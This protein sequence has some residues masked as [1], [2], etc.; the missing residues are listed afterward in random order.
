MKNLKI[1]KEI[2][3]PP[4]AVT[5]T[6]GIIGRKGAGKTYLATMVAEQM[7]DIKAQTIIVDPVGVWWGLRINADGK[8]KGKQIFVIG[9]D[10]GDIPLV[11]EAGKKVAQ[12]LVEKGISAV[13]DVSSFGVSEHKR[14]CADFGEEFFQ[15]KKKKRSP[16]MLMLEEAQLVVPQNIRLEEARMYSAFERIVRLGRNYGIGTTLITQRPQSVNKEVL[17]QVE[18]L[19]VLQVTGP[20]ER[21]ALE[22]WVQEVGADRTL[23]GELP[24]LAR[25]EGY[26]WSPQWLGIFKRVHFSKKTTFD[27]SATPEVGKAVQAASLSAVDVEKLKEDM[28]EVISQ[29]EKDDPVALRRQIAE[30]Q[31][32]AKTPVKGGFQQKFVESDLKK[33]LE[34]HLVAIAT[35]RNAWALTV[36]SWENYVEMF[37]EIV[38]NA[39]IALRELDKK[40]PSKKPGATYTPKF[41]V[42]VVNTPRTMF[43]GTHSVVVKPPIAEKPQT[44]TPNEGISGPEQ[45]ILDAIA[46]QES[47]GVDHPEQTAVAFLAGY[48]VGGGAFNNPKGSLRK[49]GLIEYAGSTLALTAEGRSMAH[50]PE[51][52]LTTEALHEKV[53]ARLDGP[54]QRIL[55]P[56][57]EAYPNGLSNEELAQASGYELGGG[58]FNNPKGRL[59]T[60]G[61]IEYL[62][63][64]QSKAKDILFIK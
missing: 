5:Q 34:P 56:L 40:R 53:L 29:A 28:A 19:C 23:I 48:K 47:I 9:G 14:F 52:E 44:N 36:E 11:P 60:L 33:A 45:R 21:K 31:K 27:A 55:K 50:V 25:G 54:Q 43:V 13:V 37:R 1:S 62:P 2:S 51:G 16:A 30:L 59:K 38:N 63:G 6:I 41:S 15:L 20:H 57:L 10:H 39:T 61:L 12:L 4:D 22:Y 24:G 64:G 35:E 8:T 42:P 46:W 18:C 26:V 7:L 32:A 58:A 49:K 3:L 17:S